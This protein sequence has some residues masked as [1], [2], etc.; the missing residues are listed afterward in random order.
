MKTFFPRRV[1]GGADQ[2]SRHAADRRPLP[3]AAPLEGDVVDLLLFLSLSLSLS[4]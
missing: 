1:A 2:H 4:A 3:P